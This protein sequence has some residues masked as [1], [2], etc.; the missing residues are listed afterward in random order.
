MDPYDS[1]SRP[2]IVAPKPIPPLRTKN[3]SV[4]LGSRQK[5]LAP[6]LHAT[7]YLVDPFEI[8]GRL[9]PKGGGLY[10]LN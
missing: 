10:E 6:T 3:Q 9:E 2:P 5:A 7:W 8:S 4:L 1:P